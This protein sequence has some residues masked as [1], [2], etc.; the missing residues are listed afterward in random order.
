[1]S[2]TIDTAVALDDPCAS[3]RGYQQ[4][5]LEAGAHLRAVVDGL[6]LSAE[7]RADR[8]SIALFRRAAAGGI[9]SVLGGGP[10]QKEG[11]P[12]GDTEAAESETHQMG[13]ARLYAA[14]A[15]P[16]AQLSGVPTLDDGHKRFREVRGIVVPDARVAMTVYAAASS[17][18]KAATEAARAA[19]QADEQ[20]QR[21]VVR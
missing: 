4:A 19:A 2:R 6:G 16:N 9:V 1:M 3:L 13:Q 20:R 8:Y 12:V 11:R 21:A 10:A 17:W 14:G 7:Q 5:E 15:C 18:V